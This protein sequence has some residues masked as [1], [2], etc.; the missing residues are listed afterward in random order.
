MAKIVRFIPIPLIARQI[1][2]LRPDI[3]LWSPVARISPRSGRVSQGTRPEFE[4]PMLIVR[5]NG[6]LGF[7]C[8]QLRNPDII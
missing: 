7:H 8:C 2:R 1:V 5:L 4:H 6:P 3:P